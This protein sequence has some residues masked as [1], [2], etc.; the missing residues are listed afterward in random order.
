M[1]EKR[2]NCSKTAKRLFFAA[3]LA[4]LL[5]ACLFVAAAC[6]KHK[7]EY[8]SSITKQPTCAE[9]GI[10]TFV[11]ECGDSYT[12]DVSALG[13]SYT[14][15]KNDG[16]LHFAVCVRCGKA[17]PDAEG[18][19]H[20][21]VKDEKAS[22]EPTCRE[23]GLSVMKCAC[24]ATVE[25]ELPLLKHELV[26]DNNESQ[27]WQ[28]CKNCD[29][30]SERIKHDWKYVSDTK[31]HHMECKI[32]DYET[33]EQK[34]EYTSSVTR[35][36]TCV[37]AGETTYTCACSYSYTEPIETIAHSY[38]ETV[39]TSANHWTVCSAC[40]AIDPDT[41]KTAHVWEITGVKQAAT[42]TTGGYDNVK[43]SVCNY[44]STQPSNKL[45][46]DF[47]TVV[48]GESNANGHRLKCARCEEFVFINHNSLT[49]E[50]IGADAD[51]PNGHNKAATCGEAGHQDKICLVCNQ[52]F[53]TVLPATG[54]HNYS[55]ELV[56][57]HGTQHWQV[58]TVC[59]GESARVNHTWTTIT[60]QPT[61]TEI[62][63]ERSVC[64]ECG[65]QRSN[66]NI[67]A[68]GHDLE[69]TVK[70]VA[71]C[72]NAGEKT[73][74][75]TR[76]GF[77]EDRAIAQLKHD[78]SGDYETDAQ[79]HYRTCASCGIRQTSG[80][81][82]NFG[83]EQVVTP[84]VNCGDIAVTRRTCTACGYYVDTQTVK[85]HNWASTD[86][87]RIDPTCGQAG[88]HYE[89]CQ[90]C[91]IEQWVVD[92]QLSTGHDL[93]YHERKEATL[94]E[95]GNI[96]YHECLICGRYF[97][98][99]NCEIEY[100]AQEI[101]LSKPQRVV[102]S[103]V[104]EL[105]AVVGADDY[106]LD[107]PSAE[108]YEITLTFC[109]SDVTGRI[110]T[111][112]DDDS[113]ITVRFDSIENL[114]NLSYGDVVKLIGNLV[115]YSGEDTINDYGVELQNARVLSVPK[116]DGL[117][118]L[119]IT[120][121]ILGD[122]TNTICVSDGST[123][124]SGT[125]NNYNCLIIDNASTITVYYY[126]YNNG[127]ILKSLVI[128]GESYTATSSGIEVE[129]TGDMYVEAVFSIYGNENSVTFAELD[130][131][132]GSGAQKID[133]YVSC[134][135]VGPE[136]EEANRLY[137]NSRL[138]INLVNANIVGVEFVFEDPASYGDED[139][140]NTNVIKLGN[141]ELDYDIEYP[142]SGDQL[143]AKVKLNNL[144]EGNDSLQYVV[145]AQARL[146]SVKITYVTH[147][148]PLAQA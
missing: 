7:H 104:A 78:W 101:V 57:T 69:E 147:N 119:Y 99:K 89:R 137:A 144:P 11:C 29:Y 93:V 51:C 90:N 55:E 76:C 37:R 70:V 9:N 22:Y 27:H 81:N 148:Q 36:A 41:P 145:N 109:E 31:M 15:L 141:T 75:C 43:C 63:H 17:Q 67:D 34:H 117:A 105:V 140:L 59:G 116:D 73:V 139:K 23:K 3:V 132:W 42:C 72:Q 92:P 95:D 142:T 66:R 134:T 121:T 103:S 126:N 5:L 10:E 97:K 84:A 58:C 83:K 128:N 77:T 21:F 135:Y 124:F 114:S 112:M 8:T 113:F 98:T 94:F 143:L 14:A 13:H 86:E 62:G 91:S 127:T 45:N 125:S 87:G 102:V 25:T 16:D 122:K 138:E 106:P 30:V 50:L 120:E 131:T 18:D 107:T 118:S 39:S 32:C 96:A 24:G 54:E 136:P 85:A 20:S 100:T 108:Y 71:T 26:F 53:H 38:T 115:W 60:Q 52:A 146:V 61:C 68:L 46:H 40:K 19:V 123:V 111:F 28:K 49:E 35:E 129:V 80:G 64:S 2:S 130:T 4:A 74:V 82:H 79:Q 110:I 6:N 133:P 48:V 44:E 65:Y 1:K 88:G 33:E 47:S 56:N 12:Q